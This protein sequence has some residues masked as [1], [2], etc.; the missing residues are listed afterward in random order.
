[1]R[2]AREFWTQLRVN[3]DSWTEI[4]EGGAGVHG[5]VGVRTDRDRA[6]ELTQPPS[7]LA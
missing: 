4:G 3:E 7:E 2:E 5:W 6:A 1:M